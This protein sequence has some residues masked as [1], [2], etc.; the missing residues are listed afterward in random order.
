MKLNWTFDSERA[1]EKP[2]I[3]STNPLEVKELRL[4]AMICGTEGT[5]CIRRTVGDCGVKSI[6]PTCVANEGVIVKV[7]A[8]V[9]VC[10]RTWV[11][12][13]AKSAW[14]V[15]AAIVNGSDLPPVTNWTAGSIGKESEVS[16]R[17]RTPV[18]ATG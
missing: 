12:P 11:W 6:P 2:V 5:I 9:P 16:L 13:L 7:D 14:V 18:K 10:S 17:V 4:T 8:T 15:L 1:V 3:A